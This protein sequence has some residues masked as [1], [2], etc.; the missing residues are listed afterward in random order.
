LLK[1]TICY[2]K[3]GSH[4]NLPKIMIQ[5]IG[6]MK[7]T[8][9]NLLG[10]VLCFGMFTHLHAQVKLTGSARKL[11]ENR[12]RLTREIP[13]QV[14]AVWADS[15]IDLNDAFEINFDIFLG[16]GKNSA[17][18]VAFVLHQNGPK[19]LG[20][21]G[22]GLG[23][24]GITPSL[25]VE[26]DNY[27]NEFEG[28]F[29][30]PDTHVA[31]MQ[32]G[33]NDH[34]SAANLA[35]PVLANPA[36]PAR[37]CKYYKASINWEPE[38]N[39]LTILVDDKQIL[40]YTGNV[41]SNIFNG[42]PE[43]FWGFTGASSKTR[44]G[45]Q[46]IMLK[47]TPISA[48]ITQTPLKCPG[49][50]DAV[51]TAKAKGGIGKLSYKWS[52]GST[53]KILKNIGAGTYQLT[54]TDTWGSKVVESVSIKN[55]DALVFTEI[56]RTA[57]P[58]F[59]NWN[60]Q[61]KGG[62]A[63]YSLQKGYLV[64]EGSTARKAYD[65]ATQNKLPAKPVIVLEEQGLAALQSYLSRATQQNPIA[66]VGVVI[67]T[68]ANG[69]KTEK[70]L[71]DYILDF[72]QIVPPPPVL[73]IAA[74]GMDT[75]GTIQNVPVAPPEIPQPVDVAVSD[76][77]LENARIVYTERNV[78]ALLN[79]RTVKTGKRVII[80]NETLNITVWDDGYE[81]GDTI[82]LFFNGEW[83]LR[84]H[85]LKNKPHKITI[86]IDRN[87]D[88]YLILYAHNEGTRPPNTAALTIQD[89]KSTKRIALSSGL[90]YCD[91]LNFKF[92]E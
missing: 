17:D 90:T 83:L 15:K 22:S 82:S 30:S 86:K 41:V 79:N 36:K 21:S 31:I 48:T 73:P 38:T 78:P 84:E 11:E 33:S 14:G 70:Y 42:K 52:N 91:A 12:Y 26:F 81:D 92:K 53:A 54:V 37:P 7:F 49:S 72:P 68:D 59:Y 69:C 20:Q 45:A 2:T 58:D 1:K 76:D 88:N 46:G 60:A 40:T 9:P 29:P 13:A 43:V 55:P 4:T 50:A 89:G 63:P 61:I 10:V 87:A 65:L 5:F 34:L 3:A 80:N 8:F 47:Y 18:G 25:I 85:G 56:T 64:L 44:I 66:L 32:N 28:F 23:Y 57:S 71:P 27:L 62:K 74:T 19:A 6:T 67:A 35:G 39:T 24:K 16:C 75:S 51:L 77:N